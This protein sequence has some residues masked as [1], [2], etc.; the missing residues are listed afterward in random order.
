MKLVYQHEKPTAD[1]RGHLDQ[2]I[3][4]LLERYSGRIKD[5]VFGWEQDTLRF[6]F[7]AL[8]MRFKGTAT[9]A[10][11]ALTIDMRLPL[12]ARGFEPEIKAR[13]MAKLD[14]LLA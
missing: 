2:A 10:S 11:Q 14:E 9:N 13:I 4:S 6:S 5:P 7:T 8:S 12:L 3:P 1:V